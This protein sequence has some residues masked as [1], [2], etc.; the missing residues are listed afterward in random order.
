[1]SSVNLIRKYSTR[2]ILIV[3][4]LLIGWDVFAYIVGKNATFSVI[5]TDWSF[6]SPWIPFAWGVLIGHWFFAPMGSKKEHV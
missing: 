4:F 2:I 5:M 3:T 6:Y 1:M